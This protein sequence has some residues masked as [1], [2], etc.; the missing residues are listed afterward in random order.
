VARLERFTDHQIEASKEYISEL[1]FLCGNIKRFAEK[2]LLLEIAVKG[3]FK[4]VMIDES[5]LHA[6]L[7][8]TLASYKMAG[9]FDFWIEQFCDAGDRYYSNPAFYALADNLDRLFDNIEVFIDNFKG[10]VELELGIEFLINEYGKKEIIN[11]FKAIGPKLSLEQKKAVNNAFVEIEYAKPFKI[12]P[13]PAKQKVYK[14]LKTAVSVAGEKPLE[15]GTAETLQEKAG[16][17]FERMGCDVQFNYH[18]AG[19]AVDIFIKRKKLFSNDF[20][21]CVCRCRE[22]ERKVI[23]EEVERFLAVG[24][25]VKDCVAVIISEKGFTKG[26]LETAKKHGIILKTLHDLETDLKDF[27]SQLEIPIPKMH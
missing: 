10:E 6:E 21:C 8:T 4:G 23:K 2:H 12:S 5:D 16:K 11:R 9:N 20:E 3:K 22:G 13:E 15:Y 7:L 19:Y 26:A 24:K 17:I 18:I 14:P 1:L 25:A 27:Y